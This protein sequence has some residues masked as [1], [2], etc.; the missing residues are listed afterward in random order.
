MEAE[1]MI[2][3]EW[4]QEFPVA[5]LGNSKSIQSIALVVGRMLV[6]S[7]GKDPSSEI[8]PCRVGRVV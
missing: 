7:S 8:L 4:V 1:E 2:M 6:V 5:V 3:G